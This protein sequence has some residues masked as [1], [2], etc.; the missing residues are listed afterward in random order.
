MLSY[1]VYFVDCSTTDL[2]FLN[3]IVY[4][5][6]PFIALTD[7]FYVWKH[8]KKAIF[9]EKILLCTECPFWVPFQEVKLAFEYG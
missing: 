9:D 8:T 5:R 7:F 3:A 6:R 4:H 1:K 2:D